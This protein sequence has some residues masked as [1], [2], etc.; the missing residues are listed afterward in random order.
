MKRRIV[1]VQFFGVRGESYTN[2]P[3]LV[4]R[5]R[6]DGVVVFRVE[7][8]VPP[9]IDIV[10]LKGYQC[11]NVGM[12]ATVDVLRRGVVSPPW[13]PKGKQSPGLRKVD[14]FCTPDPSAAQP[15][16]TPG[17]VVFYVHPLTLWQRLQR[18][19]QQ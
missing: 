10:D 13:A 5:T 14:Q 7:E 1:E 15:D 17:E 8:P 3:Q 2:A 4:G 9:F 16:A 18:D 11:S 6:S 19:W 12:F